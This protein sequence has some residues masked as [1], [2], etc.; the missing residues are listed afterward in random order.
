[1]P[2]PGRR[3]QGRCADTVYS[4]RCPAVPLGRGV[5]YQAVLRACVTFPG[6]YGSPCPACIVMLLLRIH[7]LTHPLTHHPFICSLIHSLQ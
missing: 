4:D 5:Q 1:M 2:Q 7:L 3:Q 6:D